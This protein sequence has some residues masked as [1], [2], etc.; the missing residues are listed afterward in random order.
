MNASREKSL[1]SY[2]INEVPPVE[3]DLLLLRHDPAAFGDGRCDGFQVEEELFGLDF[4][5]LFGGDEEPDALE[6]AEEGLFGGVLDQEDR[7]T[8]G[9]TSV[10]ELA[11]VHRDEGGEAALHVK[12]HVGDLPAFAGLEGFEL[13]LEVVV[14]GVLLIGEE[15]Q[16]DLV[17]QRKSRDLFFELL[18]DQED[19]GVARAVL[20]DLIL[21]LLR[22]LFSHP[23]VEVESCDP[24]RC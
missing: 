21:D 10:V 5:F 20:G 24:N 23:V 6:L 2:P 12:T 8:S 9:V 22:R 13:V 17:L 16:L 1:L 14:A 7:R 4:Y 11:Q 18:E 15:D 19:V 3:R